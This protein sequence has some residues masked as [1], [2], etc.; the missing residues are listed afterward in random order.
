MVRFILVW[1][2]NFDQKKAFRIFNFRKISSPTTINFRQKLPTV[3]CWSYVICQFLNWA[4]Y[5]KFA[6]MFVTPKKRRRTLK[7]A[8]IHIHIYL[9]DKRNELS[10]LSPFFVCLYIREIVSLFARYRSEI[11]T[12]KLLICG[13]DIGPLLYT[14]A[15]QTDRSKS[16]PCI[17]TETVKSPNKFFRANHYSIYVADIQTE[18][19]KLNSCIEN[20]FFV[21]G[22]IASL[23]P[24]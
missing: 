14:A 6:R 3:I 19:S 17:E 12:K 2:K 15:M 10:R 13:I 18:R 22:I 20:L 24:K 8:Y 7:Y 1:H 23:Q 4:G 16:G 21:K 9:Y 11:L 5:I